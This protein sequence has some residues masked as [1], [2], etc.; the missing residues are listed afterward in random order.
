MLGR[1]N[2]DFD[3][4]PLQKRMCLL[5]TNFNPELTGEAV[6]NLIVHMW[7][8]RS[9]I[10]QHTSLISCQSLV[11]MQSWCSYQNL[12]CRLTEFKNTE[13]KVLDPTLF[14]KSVTLPGVDLPDSTTCILC[15]AYCA[16]T[17]GM[18]FSFSRHET[19]CKQALCAFKCLLCFLF[20][21]MNYLTA[22]DILSL[23]KDID[24]TVP[25]QWQLMPL[26]K[27]CDLNVSKCR[28]C[29]QTVCQK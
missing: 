8:C 10:Q 6:R 16:C 11:I 12:Y 21:L 17:I 13:H 14:W 29:L 22:V 15:K 25:V 24:L 18:L 2:P 19:V 27:S 7:K 23:R 4:P 20:D 26:T 1:L 28:L 5:A 9:C 3:Y